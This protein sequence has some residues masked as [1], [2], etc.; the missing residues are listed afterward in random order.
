MNCYQQYMYSYPHKMAYGR[1]D[2]KIEDY[3]PYLQKQE[4]MLYCHIP[5]CQ[6]KCGYCNLFSI[7]GKEEWID[8]YLSAIQ[9]QSEFYK[10][11]EFMVNELVIGGGTPLLLSEKQLDKLFSI[12]EQNFHFSTKPYPI[13]IET[14]PNQTTQEK[15]AVLKKH[16]VTRV[17]IGIQS[18]VEEELKKL[19]R[20]H[21]RKEIDSALDLLKKA[22]FPCMNIDLIYGIPGQTK[23]SLLYS[24]EQ[25]LAYV[26]EEIFIYP[27]YVK[28]GTYLYQHGIKTQ[29]NAKELY[30][31]MKKHLEAHGYHQ[32][33]MR[34]FVRKQE[35]KTLSCGFEQT[36]SIGCGGRSYMGN[37]HFCTPYHVKPENCR[38]EID[39]Y[40]QQTDFSKVGNGFILNEEEQRRRY[41][42][43][44]LLHENGIDRKEYQKIFQ[45]DVLKEW[46]SWEQLRKEK[47]VEWNESRIWLTEEGMSQS[48][49]IG[50][51]FISNEVAEHMKN[52]KE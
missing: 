49:F 18:F 34:R 3:I 47:L 44:N 11:F 50:P 21:L 48:D 26:P 30:W 41:T 16:H 20:R 31:F 51:M 33:S 52:W 36:I 17:S 32:I 19:H 38:E 7:A 6:S 29:E 23:E 10:K 45:K 40:C 14:S 1:L 27:L 13:T 28:Q 15:V 8:A 46:I 5:F 12:A 43:K 4:N 37:L 22:E 24:L 25:T 42:I 9:R 35:E 2:E 39:K